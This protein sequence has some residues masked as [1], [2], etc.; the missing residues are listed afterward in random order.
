[1]VVFGLKK[2]AVSVSYNNNGS[3]YYNDAVLTNGS[4][5]QVAYTGNVTFEILASEGY[6]LLQTG[7]TTSVP[8]NTGSGMYYTYSGN[9]IVLYNVTSAASF[10]LNFT[11]K[12]VYY[13]ITLSTDANITVDTEV[14]TTLLK[15]SELEVEFTISENYTL[16]TLTIN[17]KVVDIDTYITSG[18]DNTYTLRVVVTQNVNIAIAAELVKYD[19]TITN[20]NN[21]TVYVGGED[22]ATN[23]VA[24]VTHGSTVVINVVPNAGY[25]IATITLDGENVEVT[26][27]QN[28]SVIISA[29]ASAHAIEVTFARVIIYY[30]VNV[31]GGL[32]GT[33]TNS[34]TN[35][36][37]ENTAFSVVITPNDSYELEALTV[38]GE[39]VDLT[40]NQVAVEDGVYTYSIAAVTKD[41]VIVATFARVKYDI[42]LTTIENGSV[43]V[44]TV[45]YT[46]ANNGAVIKVTHDTSLEFAFIPNEGYRLASFKV[47]GVETSVTGD[48]Y[49]LANI[50]RAHT[51]VTVFEKIE[52]TIT[53][54]NN[55]NG[56][57]SQNSIT[58]L[59]GDSASFNIT[60]NT[61]YT[62][63]GVYVDGVKDTVNIENNTTYYTFTLNSVVANHSVE[64]AFVIKAMDI[65]V[66]IEGNGSVDISTV[67]V[68]YGS[69]KTIHIYP[70]NNNH[71]LDV[72][73]NGVS[74]KEHLEQNNGGAYAYTLSNIVEA[75]NITVKFETDKVVVTSEID[76]NV[77]SVTIDK[78]GDNT[79]DYGSNFELEIIVNDGYILQNIYV[80]GVKDESLFDKASGTYTLTVNNVTK[81][82]LITVVTIKDTYTVTIGS[83]IVFAAGNESVAYKG[84]KTIYIP[85]THLIDLVA[86]SIDGARVDAN[87]IV[88]NSTDSRYEYTITN[89]TKDITVA[90]TTRTLHNLYT[91]VIGEEGGITVAPL[92]GRNTVATGAN[93]IYKLTLAQDYYIYSIKVSDGENVQDIAL[94]TLEA[95]EGGYLLELE[96]VAA[97]LDIVVTIATGSYKI[98]IESGENGKT[99][100]EE[101]VGVSYPGE[102]KI[103]VFYPNMY[104]TIDYV[105]IDGNS[106]NRLGV[107]DLMVDGYGNYCYEFESIFANHTLK[108]E[109]K[110]IE[111][112]VTVNVRGSGFGGE[113]TA[114]QTTITYGETVDY[115]L[116]VYTN[117]V[118][119]R[120]LKDGVEVD[121]YSNLAAGSYTYTLSNVT[122]DTVIDLYFADSTYDIT[123]NVND[124]S[125]GSVNTG[126]VQTV[127]YNTNF[128]FEFTANDGYI[129]EDVLLDGDSVLDALVGNTYTLENVDAEYEL[130]VI[131]N[132]KRTISITLNDE[133]AGYIN[134]GTGDYDVV[135]G[136]TNNIAVF[137]NYGYIVESITVNGEAITDI[138]SLLNAEDGGYYYVIEAI[139]QDYTIDY[140]LV[141][142]NYNVYISKT[143]GG[144]VTPYS[145]NAIVVAYNGSIALQMTPYTNNVLKSIVINGEDVIDLCLNDNGVY[146]YTLLNIKQDYNI[147]ISFASS[148]NNIVITVN[149]DGTVT[150]IPNGNVVEI[151]FNGSQAFT[152]A[153]EEDYVIASLV[154]DG[155]SIAAAIGKTEYHYAFNRVQVGHSVEVTYVPAEY[156]VQV[157]VTANGTTDKTGANKVSYLDDFSVT[158]TP[159]SGYTIKSVSINSEDYDLEALV[160][161]NGV[162]VLTLEDI[163]ENYDIV[164]VFDLEYVI[165]VNA[166]I[167]NVVTVEGDTSVVVG[168]SVQYVIRLSAGYMVTAWTIDGTSIDLADIF[169]AQNNCYIVSFTDIA[170]NHTIDI[171]LVQ[172]GYAITV[173][174]NN[175]GYTSEIG[176][177]VVDYASNKDIVITPDAHYHVASIKLDGVEILG[178]LTIDNGSYVVTVTNVVSDRLLEVEF[179]LDSVFVELVINNTTGGYVVPSHSVTLLYGQT[180]SYEIN[181]YPDYVLAEVKINNVE[182][183]DLDSIK[184]NLRKYVYTF[185]SVT[186]DQKIEITFAREKYTIQ[187]SASQGG[188][189]SANT[190]VNYNEEYKCYITPEANYEIASVSVNGV[191]IDLDTLDYDEGGYFVV[192]NNVKQNYII[193]VTFKLQTFTITVNIENE[194]YG[195]VE[196]AKNVVEYGKSVTFN[197][198]PNAGYIVA[199]VKVDGV[200]QANV[201]TYVFSSVVSDHTIDIKFAK[202]TYRVETFVTSGEDTGYVVAP[203]TV[204]YGADLVIQLYPSDHYVIGALTINGK[205][206]TDLSDI[207]DSIVIE[208]VDDDYILEITFVFTHYDITIE[209]SAGG[210]ILGDTKANAGDNKLYEIVPNDG[211]TFSKLY[212]NGVEVVVTNDNGRYFYEI[213]NINDDY[214]ISAEYVKNTFTITFMM[215]NTGWGGIIP[216]VANNVASVEYG[217]SYTTVIR[218]RTGYIVASVLV[219]GVVYDAVNNTIVLTNITENHVVNITFV[220]NKKYTISTYQYTNHGTI[221]VNS[222]ALVGQQVTFI[223]TPIEGYKIKSLHVYDGNGQDVAYDSNYTFTMP[224]SA[225][226][227]RVEY[228][229]IEIVEPDEP[230]Q[231]VVP[232]P[233]DEPTE[234]EMPTPP[235]PPEEGGVDTVM[236]VVIIIVAILA[237]GATVT[238][239]VI[240]VIK[241]KNQPYFHSK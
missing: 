241:K 96:E 10:A 94:N 18:A 157:A 29:C 56:S 230:D 41:T 135:D 46:S 70:D 79:I 130:T 204:N 115:N 151:P 9:L 182:I 179:M 176:T 121:G 23:G 228:E 126:A 85:V 131:F 66:T 6:E 78:L 208:D 153:A 227:I 159:N 54:T 223:V 195:N 44:N 213:T 212:V 238:I 236:I 160:E 77:A 199:S 3:V 59:H 224:N 154:I 49:T 189:I 200:A 161:S 34:G 158:I 24:K 139:A 137:V 196:Y 118:L 47:D 38:D 138:D 104:Y 16:A 91:F 69:T 218:P 134:V 229:K 215:N 184:V 226:N 233:G 237:V 82:T 232:G 65:S 21:G 150:P 55:D 168:S 89:I 117:Y 35:K 132:V 116:E 240:V 192:F 57:V 145:I 216:A 181:V 210:I 114:S 112:A 143:S 32:G 27:L 71:L 205:D 67:T 73:D 183:V 36:V 170:A 19:I 74:I 15:N 222:E 144:N 8:Y 141:R 81:D 142:A 167:A 207:T 31:S 123:V 95:T 162:Y 90:A 40:S 235:T 97:N 53:I 68:N 165:T 107:E 234:P 87:D 219:D 103:I 146:T 75:H 140:V 225:V 124:N 50:T 72:L 221:S 100:P 28:Q 88:Y 177:I 2:Y 148:V 33:V 101:E 206:I 58:V 147:E 5:I 156:D 30:N 175:G 211:Y 42:T 220:I 166:N 119:V 86:V 43:S 76:G 7:I 173:V 122:A 92:N 129:L 80:N 186:E 136:S 37:Q 61:G 64:V 127:A 26:N 84:D 4:A 60:P 113:M 172:T 191:D 164:V 187:N 109:F 193:R 17:N 198:T 169:D 174:S 149:G 239:I 63:G 13:D 106:A 231:P 25:E 155:N 178:D 11:E 48:T 188:S 51:I 133:N 202:A 217:S 102:S 62:V 99:L 1:M 125:M 108:V 128:T 190:L 52:Y 201:N 209:E 185:D 45:T 111:Y 12:P 83:G 203:S 197:I 152:F 93:K 120:M 110:L 163:Q 20:D 214:V 39:S 98:T 171:T 22:F 105:E 14:P 180:Q 194:A